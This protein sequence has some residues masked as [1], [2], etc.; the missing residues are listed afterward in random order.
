MA[1]AILLRLTRYYVADLLQSLQLTISLPFLQGHESDFANLLTDVKSEIDLKSK[2]NFA[3]KVDLV[4]GKL[5]TPRYSM[6]VGLSHKQC[7]RL[8]SDRFMDFFKEFKFHKFNN[9]FCL[10]VDCPYYMLISFVK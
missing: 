8:Y 10:M 1:Q 5:P 6:F 7:H 2:F 9:R 4:C 3:F